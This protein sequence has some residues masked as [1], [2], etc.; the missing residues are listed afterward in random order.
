MVMTLAA[1]DTR[2]ASGP[3][4]NMGNY[5]TCSV[6]FDRPSVGSGGFGAFHLRPTTRPSLFK[7][8][9]PIFDQMA[10][11]QRHMIWTA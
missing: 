1:R 11:Q 7:D 6:M 5:R 2:V 3:N 4:E 9:L 8:G 10:I